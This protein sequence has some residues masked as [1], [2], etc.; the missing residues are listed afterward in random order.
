MTARLIPASALTPTPVSWLWS[1]RIP[2]GAIT[3]LIGGPGQAKSSIA[4]DLTARVTT[5]RPMPACSG[6]AAPADVILLQA[7]DHPTSRVVPSLVAAG[8]DLAKVHLFDRLQDGCQPLLF[9]DDIAVIESAVAN[10]KAKLVVLDPISCY[11]NGN[12]Q[13]EQSVRK[14]LIPFAMLAERHNLAVLMVRHLR[15]NGA[16]DPIHRG[17]GSIAFV[18]LARSSL[19]VGN[20]P[21]TDDSH[22]HVLTI[23]KSNLA[24][25]SS[26]VYRTVQR[27]VGTIAIDW[28]GETKVAARDLTS[29]A[30][31]A[32]DASLL[33]EAMYVLFSLLCDGPLPAKEVARRA[34]QA[35]IT[36]RTLYRAKATLGVKSIKRGSGSGSQWFWRLPDDDRA[37]RAFKNHDLD[38][39]MDQLCHGAEELHV[40]NPFVDFPD[41]SNRPQG[42]K[43]DERFL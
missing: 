28:L 42:S 40:P 10:L 24:S 18:A 41:P 22:R 38:H 13:N 11:L 7:E 34:A 36:T 3:E 12:L 31:S 14:A 33:H 35:G 27:D 39:L 21:L 15:K 43:D 4:Y 23:N 6:A 17:A 26:L 32:T 1:D 9:P 19:L 16:N 2:L 37:Y 25:A 8:A 30:G 20:D 29:T 5:G